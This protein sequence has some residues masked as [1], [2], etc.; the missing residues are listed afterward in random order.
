M[1]R[2]IIKEEYCIGCR[3]CEIWCIVA[4]S[5]S[6][7][8][9]KAY[10]EEERPLSAIYFE[11][12][13]STSFALQCRHCSAP[14][15]LYA[16]PTGALYKD[17]WKI[18]HNKDKCIGCWMC[19]MSCPYGAIKQEVKDKKVASKCDLCISLESP[20]CVEHCPNGAIV[21]E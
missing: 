21:L 8:I 1:K 11:K 9:I 10:Q 13:G 16:C 19:I 6:K 14:L 4:H 5:E 18:L 12:E 3:L 15:C 7:N 20:V 2:I 17:E